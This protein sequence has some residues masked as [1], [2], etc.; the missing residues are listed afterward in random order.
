MK[1][2]YQQEIPKT[3]NDATNASI[4]LATVRGS[5]RDRGASQHQ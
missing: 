5:F 2:K 1:F 4:K 3:K